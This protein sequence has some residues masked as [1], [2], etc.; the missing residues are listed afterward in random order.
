MVLWAF[1]PQQGRFPQAVAAGAAAPLR[2]IMQ[3]RMLLLLFFSLDLFAPPSIF[4][5]VFNWGR[6]ARKVV[7]RRKRQRRVPARLPSLT[8]ALTH[9]LTCSRIHKLAHSVAH[10]QAPTHCAHSRARTHMHATHSY[11]RAQARPH[12]FVRVCTH[13]VPT[14]MYT[15]LHVYSL[16]VAL[17]I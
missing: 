13:S 9:S 7:L 14:L 4:C 2:A 1:S 8:E 17:T 3:G 6:G 10:A 12:G 11:S 16:T 5:V 15:C